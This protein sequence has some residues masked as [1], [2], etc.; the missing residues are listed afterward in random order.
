MIIAGIDYSLNGPSICVF[1]G[2]NHFVFEKCQFYFLS[3]VKKYS[4]VFNKN[5]HGENFD[6]YDEECERYDTISEWA[7]TKLIGC[8]QVAIEDYAFNAQG[9]VFH[10]AENT[11]ILK[12]K[13]YQSSLP[14]EVVSPSHIKKIATGKGNADKKLMYEAFVKETGVPIK[15]M[16]SPKSGEIKSPISDIVDSY[17]ICKYLFSS[18]KQV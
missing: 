17:Y 2:N 8:E 4:T 3:P 12:Y 5:I 6:E 14:L 16:I 1:E 18:L 10:I 7:M 15:D 11:G 9:R 13:C